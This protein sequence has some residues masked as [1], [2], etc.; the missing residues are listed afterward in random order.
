MPVCYECRL[1]GAGGLGPRVGRCQLIVRTLTCAL[2]EKVARNSSG[3]HVLDWQPRLH[4]NFSERACRASISFN[5]IPLL[6]QV[7]QVV[8]LDIL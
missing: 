5:P 6:R 8:A 1:R 2:H 3:C 4:E 7:L